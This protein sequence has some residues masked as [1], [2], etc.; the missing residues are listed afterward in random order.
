[1]SGI[2]PI[3][4]ISFGALISPYRDKLTPETRAKLI[5]LGI[6]VSNI[7]TETE[8][9]AKLK[10]A[11]ADKTIYERKPEL[12][13]KLNQKDKMLEKAKSLAEKLNIS[14]SD[15]DNVDRIIELIKSRIKEIKFTKG[16]DWD[17]NNFVLEMEKELGLIEQPQQAIIDLNSSLNLTA[18][19]NMAYHNLY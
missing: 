7:Q 11:Q 18:N 16:K 12:K 13:Q 1:M 10:E 14:V 2:T 19:L 5:A 6:D 4:M 15:S 8:G 17:K 3:N 9:Q